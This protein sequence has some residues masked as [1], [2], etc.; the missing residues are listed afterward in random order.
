MKPYLRAFEEYQK[1][2]RG[3]SWTDALDFHFQ[4]GAVIGT[5]RLFVMARPVG[6]Q[7]TAKQELGLCL[8][9]HGVLPGVWH[10]WAV[11]GNL[12]AL[13]MLADE[14]AVTVLHYQRHGSPVIRTLRVHDLWSRICPPVQMPG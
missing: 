10:I 9:E 4:H 11:A 12:R 2:D 6:V 5:D 7:M 3:V 14:H 1:Q 13:A 8:P